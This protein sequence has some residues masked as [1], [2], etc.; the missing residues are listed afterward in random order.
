VSLLNYPLYISTFSVIFHIHDK[1]STNILIEMTHDS[2]GRFPPK[3]I[4]LNPIKFFVNI[5]S[6]YKKYYQRFTFL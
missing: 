6:L 1:L 2:I 5:F 3:Q 4:F